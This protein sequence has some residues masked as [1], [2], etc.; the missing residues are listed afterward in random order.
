MWGDAIITAPSFSIFRWVCS[1]QSSHIFLNK[2][3]D[4]R[5]GRKT[6][7]KQGRKPGGKD[8]RKKAGTEDR[9]HDRYN[10]K[11]F[12]DDVQSNRLW[13]GE[14]FAALVNIIKCVLCFSVRY[15]L[16]IIIWYAK[17]RRV[18]LQRSRATTSFA[19]S[20]FDAVGAFAMTSQSLDQLM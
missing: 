7:G 15:A 3:R 2:M 19:M 16:S 4:E 18:E 13:N 12:V 14:L 11:Y 10:A 17:I 8:G 5:S 6:R 1:L 20:R 9:R